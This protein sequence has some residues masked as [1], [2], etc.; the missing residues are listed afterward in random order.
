MDEIAN[1]RLRDVLLAVLGGF[2]LFALAAHELLP[3]DSKWFDVVWAYSRSLDAGLSPAIL[4]TLAGV[5]LP[6][7]WK[8]L[9]VVGM[10][11]FALFARGAAALHGAS[12]LTKAGVT[13]A[14]GFLG[15]VLTVAWLSSPPPLPPTNALLPVYVFVVVALAALAACHTTPKGLGA[16]LYCAGTRMIAISVGAAIWIAMA[17]F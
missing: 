2:A 11:L 9:V 5:H 8:E 4:V 10:L 12:P 1:I 15:L 3:W 16:V 13:A 14:G 6:T 17:M 7:W